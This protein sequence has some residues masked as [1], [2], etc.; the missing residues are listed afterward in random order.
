MESRGEEARKRR[1]KQA[2]WRVQ[3]GISLHQESPIQVS[4]DL[5]APSRSSPS[6]GETAEAASR[7]ET[8]EA[9]SL[10]AEIEHVKYELQQQRREQEQEIKEAQRRLQEE[11]RKFQRQ[12][13]EHEKAMREKEEEILKLRQKLGSLEGNVEEA[14]RDKHAALSSKQTSKERLQEISKAYK[15]LAQSTMELRREK[16]RMGKELEQVSQ[17]EQAQRQQN[18]R[19]CK[20]FPEKLEEVRRRMKQGLKTLS[21]MVE[22]AKR[23]RDEQIRTR[24]KALRGE[25][26]R[27]RVLVRELM[28]A[29]PN[30]EELEDGR[31]EEMRRMAVENKQLVALLGGD[32]RAPR[33][34]DVNLWTLY[35]QAREEA[36]G[37]RKEQR[38][39]KEGL[40]EELQWVKGKLA[41]AERDQEEQSK[42][43]KRMAQRLQFRDEKLLLLTKELEAAREE[44]ETLRKDKLAGSGGSRR[45]EAA[46]EEEEEEARGVGVEGED[47][48]GIIHQLQEDK[49]L[50]AQVLQHLRK[51]CK[52]LERVLQDSR[53]LSKPSSSSSSSVLREQEEVQRAGQVV[54]KEEEEEVFSRISE[55]LENFLLAAEDAFEAQAK[56]SLRRRRS[57]EVSRSRPGTSSPPPKLEREE[58]GGGE[59]KERGEDGSAGS[60][61][62]AGG[63]NSVRARACQSPR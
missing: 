59:Q 28:R 60:R 3:R 13:E 7:G 23:E 14:E 39:V 4:I 54:V 47:K 24:V 16:T 27:L 6:R 5:S 62:D 63:D 42:E 53:R 15:E 46:G 21:S 20:E 8:A 2:A 36:D 43:M 25:G 49:R 12:A 18:V 10:R 11:R 48:D 30:L 50:Q 55:G 26:Q 41:G 38:L 32:A 33:H 1:A 56:S 35:Q 52:E 45:E 34:G 29:S 57:R 58:R 9:A 40:H 44:L 19:L 22:K 31:M 61:A 37:V 51:K 17:Q